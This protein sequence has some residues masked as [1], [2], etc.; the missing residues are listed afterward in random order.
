MFLDQPCSD[1]LAKREE[2]ERKG[3]IGKLF[4]VGWAC[5]ASVISNQENI[6]FGFET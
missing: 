2:I 4:Q 1:I 5:D 3:N 6:V